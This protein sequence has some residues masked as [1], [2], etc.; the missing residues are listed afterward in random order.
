MSSE[1]LT[2]PTGII[3][4]SL[5]GH[6][7]CLIIKACGEAK[8]LEM[9][10]QDLYLCFGRPT[11]DTVLVDKAPGPLSDNEISAT[12]EKYAKESLLR[13]ELQTREDQLAEMLIL[14][15]LMAEELILKGE[16]EP[17]EGPDDSNE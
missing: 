6:E 1:K 16:L 14:D 15:P 8:V 9:K 13:D 7:I 12:Q 4:N 17:D 3:K 5:T 11:K 2:K 10:F